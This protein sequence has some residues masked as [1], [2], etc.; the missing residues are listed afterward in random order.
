MLLSWLCGFNFTIFWNGR[1]QIPIRQHRS[2]HSSYSFQ[3]AVLFLA[4]DTGHVH[5]RDRIIEVLDS[6]SIT[7]FEYL[8]GRVFG[9]AGLLWLVAATNICV[10][11]LL[12]LIS[13]T[14]NIGI[15]DTIEWYSLINLL[16]IDGPATLLAWCS[17]VVFLSCL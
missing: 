13:I 15:A 3:F 12:G 1:T 14:T 10:M 17:I 2:K 4:F 7:N 5:N 8:A 6:K 11:Q 9:I 16:V